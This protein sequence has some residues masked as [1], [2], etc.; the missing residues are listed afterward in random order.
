MINPSSAKANHEQR[1][2]IL[3]AL[4]TFAVGIAVFSIMTKFLVYNESRVGYKLYDPVLAAIHPIDLSIVIFSCT[5]GC[6]LIG[7]LYCMRTLR[8][9]I[10]TNLSI[11]CIFTLRMLMI[12]LVPLE[13]PDGIIPLRDSFLMNTSYADQVLE[14]DLFFSGHTASLV[15]LHYL[16]SNKF[17]S[18]VF[19]VMSFVIGTMLIIQHVHYSIDVIAAYGFS[20][21]AYRI[22]SYLASVLIKS[23]VT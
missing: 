21:L 23:N 20:Y 7:L 4:G 8:D 12:Y 17:V 14:K 11:I 13:A 16:V 15:L 9:V 3:L 2:L 5:Y 22:G 6:I 18:R 19:L 10:K 1:F